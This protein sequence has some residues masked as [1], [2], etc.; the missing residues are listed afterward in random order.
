MKRYLNIEDWSRKEHYYFFGSFSEPFFGVTVQLDCTNTYNL[1]KKEG[2]PFFLTY[3]YKSLIAANQVENF[4]YRKEHDKVA[5]YDQVDPAPTVPRADNTFGFCTFSFDPDYGKFIIN[6]KRE[7]EKVRNSRSLDP[8][9]KPNVIQYSV[10]PWLNFTSNSHARHFAHE[11]SI[12]KITFGKLENVNGKWQ[13]PM[14]VHVNHALMDGYHVGQ[15]V[16]YFQKLLNQ[17]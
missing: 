12:P 9:I 6:A 17:P 14:S 3:L 4:R 15:Y 10:L 2:K 8:S 13:M 5:V 7:I 1:V 11:D 16:E